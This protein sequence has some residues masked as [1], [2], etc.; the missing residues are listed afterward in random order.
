MRTKRPAKVYAPDERDRR[1]L[2]VYALVSPEI[3]RTLRRLSYEWELTQ[4]E[5]VQTAI[6]QYLATQA[7]ALERKRPNE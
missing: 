7:I 4:A 2:V 6:E 3:K 5:I 1:G